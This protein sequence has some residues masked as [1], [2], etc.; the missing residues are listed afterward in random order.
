MKKTL[1]NKIFIGFIFLSL[2]SGCA[3]KKTEPVLPAPMPPVNKTTSPVKEKTSIFYGSY[4][5]DMLFRAIVINEQDGFRVVL[6]SD[7]GLM[8][9]D[10]KIRPEGESDVYYYIAYMPKETVKEF[11]LFFQEYYFVAEKENIK[12]F[13]SRTYFYKDNNPVLWIKQI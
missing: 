13:K 9:Q 1:I 7:D 10:M 2:F 3:T 5:E 8:L 4:K 11:V 12:K 6:L